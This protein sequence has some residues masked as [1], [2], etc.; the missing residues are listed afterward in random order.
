MRAVL[1]TINERRRKGVWHRAARGGRE[2][3]VIGAGLV[4]WLNA[5]LFAEVAD[6]QPGLQPGRAPGQSAPGCDADG[7]LADAEELRPFAFD[8]LTPAHERAAIG[9]R[10]A[11]CTWHAWLQSRNRRLATVGGQDL[12]RYW[13]DEVLPPLDGLCA[14]FK[15]DGRPDLAHLCTAF[16]AKLSRG[17]PFVCAFGHPMSTLLCDEFDI[18]DRRGVECRQC[19]RA[20]WVGV[21]P[22]A[23]RG[24]AT[25]SD[26]MITQ[27]EEL[28]PDGTVNP[29][30]PHFRGVVVDEL[31][32]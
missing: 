29:Q 5:M 21:L 6:P 16:A 11:F 1:S 20:E 8:G 4:D 3:C 9:P 15:R 32:A 13:R 22:E 26:A 7:L 30:Q 10:Q 14:A 31:L 18:M 19:A 24:D 2:L 25:S 23:V 12:W 27:V 17:F 28:L